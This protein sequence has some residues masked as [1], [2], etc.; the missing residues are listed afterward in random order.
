MS[1]F[2]EIDISDRAARLLGVLSAGANIIGKVGL[3]AAQLAGI[4]LDATVAAVRDRLPASLVS[5][6]LDTNLGAWL[7]ATTPTV[8]QKTK[9]ASI[10]VTLASDQ[11]SILADRDKVVAVS[12]RVDPIT[13]AT[14]YLLGIDLDNPGGVYKHAAGTAIRLAGVHGTLLKVTTAN[15]WRVFVGTVLAINAVD[16]T[17]GWIG[18]GALGAQDTGSIQEVTT[19][20]P[21]PILADLSFSA[22]DYT[23][24]AA[25]HKETTTALNT[26][27]LIP[28][29]SGVNRTPAVGDLVLRVER[30]SG[31]SN[32][33]IH[34]LFWYWV[35]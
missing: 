34:Y 11:S 17:I 19:V 10:P 5:G 30:I 22:G 23:K 24:I 7:G 25:S 26:G 9:A 13:A 15:Q 31:G 28:D 12:Y 29:V 6:R 27:S 14:T 3:D 4:A 18:F 20:L 8:G 35:E 1:F 2:P 33:L 16:A 32:A 21:F